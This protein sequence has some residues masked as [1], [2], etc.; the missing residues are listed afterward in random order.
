MQRR[1]NRANVSDGL[2]LAAAPI[3]RLEEMMGNKSSQKMP[4]YVLCVRNEN[5]EDQ[6]H[7]TC[8]TQTFPLLI[9]ALLRSSRC[10]SSK[11]GQTGK[12]Q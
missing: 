10:Q 5:K 6:H 9:Y 2:T 4:R 11:W 3:H 1:S 8:T 7:L 12:Q